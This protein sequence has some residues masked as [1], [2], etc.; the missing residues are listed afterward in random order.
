VGLLSHA[1]TR[2]AIEPEVCAAL[3]QLGIPF[4]KLNHRGAPDLLIG[5]RGRNLLIE[6]KRPGGKLTPAQERFH[7]RW[8]GQVCICRSID[9]VI[10][11]INPSA[12]VSSRCR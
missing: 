11:L 3:R 2:D 12:I 1:N 4:E 6:L 9:E 8:R 10:E 7:S 5:W